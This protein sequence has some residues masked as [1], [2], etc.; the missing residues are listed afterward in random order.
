MLR[1]RSL[2]IGYILPGSFARVFRAGQAMIALQ[3]NNL[4]LRTGY[5]G[6][7]PNVNA[8]ASGNIS[9]DYGQIPPPR[10]W[11]VSFRLSR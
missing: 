10:E 5:R 7:D 11:T 3:G 9:A 1:F 4:G 8:Y 6:M 2:S